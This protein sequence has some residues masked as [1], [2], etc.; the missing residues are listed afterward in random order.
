MSVESANA[1][2]SRIT[3]DEVFRT[4]LQQAAN[5]EERKQIM[6]AAGYEFT[7]EEWKAT[8]AQIQVSN[9]ADS[10]LSDAELE[11]VSGGAV[12]LIYGGPNLDLWPLLEPTT[13][14]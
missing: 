13:E 11:A 1:F 8:T 14:V 2:F 6:Q 9:S 7:P 4:Q 10:E 12:G 3:T 5:K